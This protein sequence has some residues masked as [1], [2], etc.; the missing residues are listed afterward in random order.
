ML[1]MIQQLKVS[2]A[3]PEDRGSIPST[4]MVTHN[5]L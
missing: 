5:G 1:E 4:H 3:F 2:T